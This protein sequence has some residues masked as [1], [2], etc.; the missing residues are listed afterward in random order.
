MAKAKE[1]WTRF[2]EQI[3]LYQSSCAS[4]QQDAACLQQCQQL[5]AR[6][7]KASGTNW[8]KLIQQAQ[9]MIALT[10]LLF[11]AFTTDTR[12]SIMACRP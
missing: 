2:L 11:C 6:A 8:K 3:R 10:R 1:N 4:G 7:T 9:V 5:L 12:V